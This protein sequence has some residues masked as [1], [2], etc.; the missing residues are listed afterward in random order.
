MDR[1]IYVKYNSLRKPEYRIT[2][3]IHES[4]QMKWVVKRPGNDAAKMHLNRIAT[5]QELA[6]RIYKDISVLDVKIEDDQL[7][8]PFVNGGVLTDS[9]S[10]TILNQEELIKQINQLLDL[11]LNVREECK[12]AFELTEGFVSTFGECYPERGT[13]AICPANLDSVL[14]N[15]IQSQS[16]LVCLDYEWVYDFPVPIEFI[17]YRSIRYFYNE[18][19]NSLFDGISRDTVMEWF[20]FDR[21]KQDMYWNM[22]AYFQ[23]KIYGKD[24]R[25]LYFDRYRKGKITIQS[26]DDEIENL[27]TIMQEKDSSI[28]DKDDLINHLE[29][30]LRHREETIN[31]LNR[32]MCMREEKKK[33]QINDLETKRQALER[34]NYEIMHSTSWRITKPLRVVG[35]Y[36]KLIMKK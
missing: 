30:E 19:M 26:L 9:I 15:F 3:E 24:W 32:E 7:C 10:F 4:E 11:I 36:I 33:E 14:S 1:V 21:E 27:K 5:N 12:C 34:T 18:R 17:K 23:Q 20:G 31:E 25:Y 16:G 6:K 2:T 35:K 8:F 29:N 22:E 13:P 28:H